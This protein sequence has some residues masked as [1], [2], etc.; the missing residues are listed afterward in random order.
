MSEAP[1]ILG[2]H[3]IEHGIRLIV[4]VPADLSYFPGHFPAH[5]VLPGVVQLRWIEDLARQY[6]LIDGEFRS[7]EKLKFMRIISRDYTVTLELTVPETNV[8]QFQFVSEHGLHASG[9]MLFQ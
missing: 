2:K 8:L 3:D 4:H 1:E 6:A 7:L 5:P 9:K